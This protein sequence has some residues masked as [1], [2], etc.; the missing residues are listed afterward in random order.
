M[1]KQSQKSKDNNTEIQARQ[2]RP[3]SGGVAEDHPRFNKGGGCNNFILFT[4]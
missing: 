3:N 2:T 4:R 1:A